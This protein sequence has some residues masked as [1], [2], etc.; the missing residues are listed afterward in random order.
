MRKHNL[1]ITAIMV[2]AV[3][4]TTA[5]GSEKN[6]APG[7]S[8]TEKTTPTVNNNKAEPKDKNFKEP[9][10]SLAERA[11]S[12]QGIRAYQEGQYDEALRI[13]DPVL[14]KNPANYVALSAKGMTLS[15]QGN[16]E[17]GL[18]YIRQAYTTNPAYV[19]IYYDMAIAYKLEGRLEDSQQWFQRVIEKE[20]GNTWALYGISTIYAD[21]GDREKALSFLRQAIDTDPSVKATAREQDHFA[22]FIGDPEFDTLTLK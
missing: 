3:L 13:L 12:D 15:L 14:Q 4:L 8:T 22:A 16:T 17:E 10:I 2:G 18:R 1:V 7:A 11:I 6:T 21:R 19:P 9:V 5:C 20:P